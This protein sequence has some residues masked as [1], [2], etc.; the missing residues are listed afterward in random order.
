MTCFLD[1]RQSTLNVSIA[2]MLNMLLMNFESDWCTLKTWSWSR[3]LYGIDL[4]LQLRRRPIVLSL[5]HYSYP[6]DP[7]G[8]HMLYPGIL[9]MQV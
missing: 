4:L 2:N 1:N 8:G 5:I 6:I 9:A 3:D 7:V